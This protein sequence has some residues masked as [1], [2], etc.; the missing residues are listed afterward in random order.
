MLSWE[1]MTPIEQAQSIYWDAFKDAYGFRPR[2][3]DTTEWLLTDFH[4]EILVL[5]QVIVE[6]EILRKQN[7][8]V[9]ADKVERT[10]LNLLEAGAKDREMCIKWLLEAHDA[11]TDRNYLCF[12]LDLAYG[13]FD[14]KV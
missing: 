4:K 14:V 12:L 7:E 13:Y 3:I 5:E 6:G 10:I 2:N 11:G 9:A 1:E 8:A